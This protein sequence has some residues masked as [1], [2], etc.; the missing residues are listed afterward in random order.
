MNF[1]RLVAPVF[2]AVAVSITAFIAF[3]AYAASRQDDASLEAERLVI[4]Q[5]V[6]ALHEALA[7]L[8]EDNAWWDAAVENIYLSHDPIAFLGFQ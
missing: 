3:M 2:L 8:V 4:A 1:R 6:R 5:E 7:V